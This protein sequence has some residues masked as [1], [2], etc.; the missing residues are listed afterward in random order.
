M[1][2]PSLPSSRVGTAAIPDSILLTQQM[3]PS[4]CLALAPPS[5]T[6]LSRGMSR[7]PGG[8]PWQALGSEALLFLGG[9]PSRSRSCLPA[10]LVPWLVLQPVHPAPCRPCCCA[11]WQSIS[12]CVWWCLGGRGGIPAV[13]SVVAPVTPMFAAMSSQEECHRLRR[14]VS[15]LWSGPLHPG[16]RPR[17][18]DCGAGPCGQVTERWE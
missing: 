8:F 3:I 5:L 18:V 10:L 2:E 15:P 9:C 12:P 16:R 17:D 6:L 1:V 4:R 7:P 13:V 14:L 11:S